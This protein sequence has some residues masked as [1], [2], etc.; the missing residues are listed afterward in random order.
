ME[1][2]G[3]PKSSTSF[4]ARI[5]ESCN[6]SAKFSPVWPPSVASKPS[7][8]SFFMNVNYSNAKED[9]KLLQ[10]F[11]GESNITAY[12]SGVESITSITGQ[13]GRKE[14]EITVETDEPD[15]H[16]IILIDNSL[17]IKKEN[18]NKLKQFLVDFFENK[19]ANE[20][21]SIA[22]YGEEINYI[23]EYETSKDVLTEK[24]NTITFINQESYLTDILYDEIERLDSLKMYTRF[25]IVSDGVDNKSIG[26]TKEELSEILQ[27]NN[28]PVYALGSL[29]RNNESELEG[30]FA[31]SRMTGGKHYLLDD[32]QDSAEILDGL[33]EKVYMLI[34]AVPESYRDGSDQNVLFTISTDAGEQELDERLSMPFQLEESSHGD[35]EQENTKVSEES[36]KDIND[37][38]VTMTEEKQEVKTEEVVQDIGEDGGQSSSSIVTIMALVIVLVAIIILIVLALTGKGANKD[39]NTKTKN[40]DKQKKS[41]KQKNAKNNYPVVQEEFDKDE[42]V[43]EIR[44][45]G[46]INRQYK[47]M[48]QDKEV[49]ERKFSYPMLNGNVVIGRLREAGVHIALNYDSSVSKKHCVISVLNERFFIED[50]GSSN[51]TFVNGNLISH[52]EELDRGDLI[53]LGKLE[54]FVDFEVLD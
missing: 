4:A 26:Y 46:V 23:A 14:A 34:V 49:P 27:E 39:K 29:Y 42:D 52:K 51:G 25:I 9:A 8:F 22:V 6:S 15:T 19:R 33:L 7:G 12:I 20:A 11:Q 54:L 16:T 28:F 31:L 45:Q 47:L 43:T 38:P 21:V 37:I 18:Q 3:V 1:S 2:I 10:Y 32:C 50:M 53:R 41:R 13:I 17:S 24:L 35:L 30:L 40:D 44:P 5:P 48:L 36:E